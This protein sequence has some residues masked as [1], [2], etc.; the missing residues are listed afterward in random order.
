MKS[1][2][3]KDLIIS[4]VAAALGGYLVKKGFEYLKYNP[5][6]KS[7]DEDTT[8]MNKVKQSVNSMVTKIDNYTG[9]QEKQ[10]EKGIISTVAYMLTVFGLTKLLRKAW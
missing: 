5:R 6:E 8:L 2:P 7:A 4:S 9:R 1:N 10:T 3:I